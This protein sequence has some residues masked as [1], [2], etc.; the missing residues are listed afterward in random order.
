MC[1]AP[2]TEPQISLSLIV[3]NVQQGRDTRNLV[4]GS[5]E[6]LDHGG[7]ASPMSVKHQS[8]SWES[9]GN[10]STPKACN[11]VTDIP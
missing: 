8:G 10:G 4:D 7:R 9:G 1:V 3:F 2:N 11:S 5:M 6:S